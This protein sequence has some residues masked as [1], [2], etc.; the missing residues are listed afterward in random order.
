MHIELRRLRARQN[1]PVIDRRL[2]P[3]PL[4]CHPGSYF[5]RPKS[6][7]APVAPPEGR[8]FLP[9]G[10]RPKIMY[11]TVPNPTNILRTAVNVSASG[12]LRTLDP[13]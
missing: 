9:M 12:G 1:K 13:L 4:C 5:K 10:G 6:S 3:P 8:S 7:P 2:R 11:H